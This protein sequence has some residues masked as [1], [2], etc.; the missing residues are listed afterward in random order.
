MTTISFNMDA[1]KAYEFV[2][3]RFTPDTIPMKRLAQYLDKLSGLLGRQENIHFKKITSGSARPAWDVEE[4]A[5]ADVAS[6]LSA[7]NDGS[8]AQGVKF[9]NEIN[10]MLM[11]DGQVAYLRVLNGPK[12]IE[13]LGRKTPLTQEVTVHEL[14]ELEGV[15]IRVGGRDSTVPVQIQSADGEYYICGTTR[16]IAK[17]LAPLLFDKQIRVN[18]KGRWRRSTEGVWALE[19]FQIVGFELV[20]DTPLPEFLARMRAVP[21]SGWNEM[22]DPQAELKRI[23]GD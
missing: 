14:G 23:R 18:G 10:R 22:D 20:G 3:D 21:G 13:F 15:V 1:P 8:S 4:V 5:R 9:R 7:A 11:D 17:Q 12:V 6:N 2:M 16:A 19:E